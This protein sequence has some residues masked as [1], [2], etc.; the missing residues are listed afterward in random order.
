MSLIRRASRT[1]SSLVASSMERYGAQPPV[2]S[3]RLTS[4]SAMRSP[5]RTSFVVDLVFMF[6]SFATF[7]PI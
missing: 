2:A 5:S 3:A 6:V 4:T 1:S 7:R